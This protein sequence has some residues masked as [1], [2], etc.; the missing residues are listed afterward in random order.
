MIDQRQNVFTTIA[1]EA[2]DELEI[3]VAEMLAEYS[4]PLGYKTVPASTRADRQQRVAEELADLLFDLGLRKEQGGMDEIMDVLALEVPEQGNLP[5]IQVLTNEY[6][7]EAMKQMFALLAEKMR[8]LAQ[9]PPEE[10][11]LAEETT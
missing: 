3:L 6:G 5:I 11:Y 7:E 1:V 2:I 10:E 8:V 9:I 4:V